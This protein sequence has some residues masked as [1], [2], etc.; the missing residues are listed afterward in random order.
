MVNVDGRAHGWGRDLHL[1]CI[2]VLLAL[3]VEFT[4]GTTLE[5]ECDDDAGVFG[6][7]VPDDGEVG[8]EGLDCLEEAVYQKAR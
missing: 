4:V 1:G 3:D 6:D 2:E 8:A 7:D 5:L